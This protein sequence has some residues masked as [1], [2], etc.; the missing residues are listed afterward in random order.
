M[1]KMVYF[2]WGLTVATALVH[3][4]CDTPDASDKANDQKTDD[5]PG[6][7]RDDDTSI[8]D[9]VEGNE[10][11]S[12]AV[13]PC[14]TRWQKITPAPTPQHLN[15]IWGASADDIFIVGASG[16]I[17]R[18]SDTYW[19]PMATPTDK[20]LYTV[21]GNS[22]TSVYAGGDGP[23][24]LYFDGID[25]R[26]QT[27]D[28]LPAAGRIEDIWSRSPTEIYAVTEE[29]AIWFSDGETWSQ[30]DHPQANALKSVCGRGSAELFAVGEAVPGDIP[31]GI[32]EDASLTLYWNGTRWDEWE[33]DYVNRYEAIWCAPDHIVLKGFFDIPS[34]G[35]SSVLRRADDELEQAP[36]RW[37]Y[38][39][40]LWGFGEDRVCATGCDF[41][42]NQDFILYCFEGESW[43]VRRLSTET[44]PFQFG[45][46]YWYIDEG[47]APGPH[48]IWGTSIED[49]YLAG[50]DGLIMHVTCE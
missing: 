22:E 30:M 48:A 2:G 7:K 43:N 28:H 39:S 17:L 42:G 46:T 8:I 37:F 50:V 15:D 26:V 34:D 19:E 1:L 10:T 35:L 21:W 20:D 5:S 23:T 40:D 29:G 4:A 41:L 18:G 9:S 31:F 3:C 49:V 25:W 14:N 36:E 38:L 24:I 47:T 13:S 11:D 6:D 45:E 12:P 27:I 16:T 32:P 44:D 33:E